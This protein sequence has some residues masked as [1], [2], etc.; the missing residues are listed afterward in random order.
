MGLM[1]VSHDRRVLSVDLLSL[2]PVALEELLKHAGVERATLVEIDASV[3]EFSKRHLS[4]I[5]GQA[6]EDR[7]LEL[8][9]ADGVARG[10][11]VIAF[12]F[13]VRAVVWLY[14]RWPRLAFRI[15]LRMIRDFRALRRVEGA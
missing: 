13:S 4:A 1:P 2:L 11:A 8:V 6:F 15:G 5:C 9:I 3:V 10:K 14:R 12:P 7:R